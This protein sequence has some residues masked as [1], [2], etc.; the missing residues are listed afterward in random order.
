[1]N[2]NLTITTVIFNNTLPGHKLPL[3]RGA[4]IN[5]LQQDNILF[6]NHEGEGLRYSYPLIQYKLI[7]RHAAIVCIG[8]GSEAVS[9]FFSAYNSE[10]SLAGHHMTLHLQSAN[11]DTV[12][13]GIS[14]SLHNYRL[15]GWMPLNAEN[16][17][18]YSDTESISGKC[19][20]LENILTGNILAF[21]KGIGLFFEEKIH[22]PITDI[23]RQYVLTY[24]NIKFVGLDILFKSNVLLPS[25]IGL[26]KGVSVGFGTV[27]SLND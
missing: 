21:A 7:N 18:H 3:F 8:E 4:V 13:I 24:K 15:T 14:E 20:I 23:L 10:I 9:S 19:R 26:G 5:M 12:T 6:H 16:Y 27:T 25:G 1:M 2:K 22:C 11:C 17:R